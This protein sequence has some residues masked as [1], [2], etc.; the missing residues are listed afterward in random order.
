LLKRGI[1]AELLNATED[2]CRGQ[3]N[4]T[5]ST[6]HQS[7]FNRRNFMG[8][9]RSQTARTLAMTL[10]AATCATASL[11]QTP[12]APAGGVAVVSEPGKAGAV[13]AVEVS[14]SVVGIDKATRTVTLNGPKGNTVK[15]DDQVEV[16][17]TEALALSV[18][19]AATQNQ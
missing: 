11:A 10:I 1:A 3:G 8:Q 18:E 9:V 15:L 13:R 14:A 19:P 4:A 6:R 5:R 2:E 17:Y 12:A 16:T 7:L